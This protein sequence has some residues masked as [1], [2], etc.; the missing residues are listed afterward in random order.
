VEDVNAS[1]AKVQSELDGKVDAARVAAL[2]D[3]VARAAREETERLE[4]VEREAVSVRR[5]VFSELCVGRWIWRSCELPSDQ[6]VPWE[7]QCVNT[8]ADNFAWE[9]ARAWVGVAAPGL[10]ELRACFFT[11]PDPRLE[12]LVDDEPV[13]TTR[14]SREALFDAYGGP[15]GGRTAR[16]P[17]ART[18]RGNA[19]VRGS[20]RRG[21]PRGGDR[22]AARATSGVVAVAPHR[23][24]PIIRHPHSAG[25]VTGCSL[26]TFLALPARARV[27]V[28]YHGPLNGVQGFMSLRKL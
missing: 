3:R 12:V 28:R 27:S 8:N 18:T 1:L 21:E 4:A 14:E 11:L 24:P 10:Y 22:S 7:V 17:G 6:R 5:R 15:T 23:R 19:G 9:A 13:V 26:A 2:E 20:P 16:A 25:N